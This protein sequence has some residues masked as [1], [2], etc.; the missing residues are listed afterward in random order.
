MADTLRS[1]IFGVPTV[2]VNMSL[3]MPG[4]ALSQFSYLGCMRV[5]EMLHAWGAPDWILTHELVI[6][7]SNRQVDGR[8]GQWADFRKGRTPKQMGHRWKIPA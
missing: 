3:G 7:V 1:Y 6:G 8:W 5:R 2:E 4:N